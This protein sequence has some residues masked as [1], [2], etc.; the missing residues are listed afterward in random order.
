MNTDL[1]LDALQSYRS[2]H[3]DPPDFDD[4]WARTLAETRQHELAVESAPVDSPLVTVDAHD[5]SFAGFGGHRIRAWLRTPAGATEP[6]P[7]VVEFLGYGNGRSTP[8][9]SLLWASLGYAHLVMDTRGQGAAWSTGDTPD[10]GAGSGPRTPGVMTDG[11]RSPETYYYRR[12]IADAVRAVETAHELPQIHRDRIAVAG[13]SQG[14]ALAL[15]A[16][17]LAPGVRA[18][19]IREPFLC[20]I[21]RAITITD[22]DPYRE[23]VRYLAVHR[24][25]ADAVLATLAHV[26]GVSFARRATVPALFS[27]AMMDRVCPPSTVFG[28]YHE[29]VGSKRI[30]V[31]PF[32]DHEGGGLASV[33]AASRFFSEKL[34]LVAD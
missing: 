26:D 22:Q 15:A 33:L 9:D 32:N 16:A 19:A 23:L 6:L 5:V 17:A 14:G 12:V 25:E 7:G 28:A 18:A 13:G 10:P 11:I 21:A 2:A 31:W 29:Y 8:E 4:F 20:D 27:V 24:D 3:V 30:D 34:G 1:D